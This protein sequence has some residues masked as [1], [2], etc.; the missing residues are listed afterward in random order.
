M[1]YVHDVF[2]SYKRDPIQDEWLA[3]HFIPLF[4]H[5][6]RQAVAAEC[7]RAPGG[8]FFDQT[9]LSSEARRF[10]QGG[11]EPGQVWRDA[12]ANAIQVSRCMVALWSPLYFYSEW[13][14]IEWHSFRERSVA[15]GRPVVVPISVH[16][17]EAFPL[18]AQAIQGPDFSDYVIIGAG[19]KETKL[20]PEFQRAIR[21]FATA[22]ARCVR[23]AP[24][25][26]ISDCKRRGGPA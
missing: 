3:T 19:F 2:I 10:D 24:E 18:D 11:I 22:V 21:T 26:D 23:Q 8:I 16:D 4:L 6:V 5:S 20:Y 15:T 17:G 12:L 14:L 25:F 1:P 7:R 9:E 13:C